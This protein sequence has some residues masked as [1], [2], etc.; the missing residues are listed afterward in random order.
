M[1]ELADRQEKTPAIVPICH[2][3]ISNVRLG[4]RCVVEVEV[5]RSCIGSCMHSYFVQYVIL[6]ACH[7][8]VLSNPGCDGKAGRISAAAQNSAARSAFCRGMY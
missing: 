7:V 3:K 1:P 6:N 2:L 8:T 4:G 5:V